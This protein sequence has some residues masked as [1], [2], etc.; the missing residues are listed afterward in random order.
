MEIA[1]LRVFSYLFAEWIRVMHMI[2]HKSFSKKTRAVALAV[3]ISQSLLMTPW[4]VQ[5]ADSSIRVAGQEI[6]AITSSA[7]GLSPEQRA[8]AIQRNIDNALVAAKQ[9]TPAAVNIVY[10]KG[11]PV[12]TLGG[13]QVVTVDSESARRSGTT[14]ALL[15]QTWANALRQVLVDS[16]SIESYVAQLTGDFS[17]SAPPVASQPPAAV[18]SYPPA[19]TGAYPADYSTYGGQMQPPVQPGQPQY[20]GRV[21]Y[22]PAGMTMQVILRT[23]ISTQASRPGDLVEGQIDQSIVLNDVTIPAGS[24]VIGTITQSDP[25]RRLGRSGDLAIKFNRLRTPDGSETPISA[26]I[27]GEIGDYKQI[28]SEQSGAVKGEGMGTKVGQLALRGAIGAG[29]GA[30]LGTAIGAI[31]GRSGRATGRGAW[32]GAAIG[33][34]LGAADSLLLRKGKDVN[35][36]SGSMIQLQLDAP[37]QVSYSGV[38]P[39]TGAF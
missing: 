6:F 26:H 17:N 27:V 32:S 31:A 30:A 20:R 9:K 37:A 12:V 34:G 1:L 38:P 10:V 19:P 21:A 25:G 7:G 14:P 4:P 16:A 5:A 28:G 29:T 3:A 11:I 24:R 33:G 8:E 13:F 23:S 36:R 15:A 22:I 2:S 39:Y 18:P 35:I